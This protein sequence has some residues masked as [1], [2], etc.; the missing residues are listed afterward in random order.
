MKRALHAALWR[1]AATNIDPDTQTRGVEAMIEFRERHTRRIT[2]QIVAHVTS[3]ATRMHDAARKWLLAAIDMGADALGG[4][5]YISDDPIA[6]L[7]MMFDLAGKSGLPLDLHIDEHLNADKLLFDTPCRGLHHHVGFLSNGVDGGGE[8]IARL[9]RSAVGIAHVQVNYRRAR[10]SAA[11]R[12]V[13]DLE[14]RDGNVGRLAAG[15]LGPHDG[16]GQDHLRGKCRGARRRKGRWG[17][18]CSSL[19]TTHV[20]LARHTR[21]GGA[22]KPAAD[23]G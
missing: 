11:R 15:H 10:V 17:N 23:G 5:P 14:G 20:P 3:G 9:A 13:G 7:D 21:T 18:R 19:G 4:V 16:C 8:Q 2:V 22:I 1:S 6:F 12:F